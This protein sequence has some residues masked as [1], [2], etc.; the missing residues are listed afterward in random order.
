MNLISLKP[1]RLLSPP[2]RLRYRLKVASET[3][4][5]SAICFCVFVSTIS[6]SR[7]FA[8]SCSGNSIASTSLSNWAL[9]GRSSFLGFTGFSL[10]GLDKVAGEWDLVALAYNCKRI[11]KLKLEMAS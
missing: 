4:M 9:L 3:P 7:A 6:V 5:S 11:H 10:R 2:I 8:L 1:S